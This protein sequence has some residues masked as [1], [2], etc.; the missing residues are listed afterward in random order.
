MPNASI[1]LKND[2]GK[3]K[4]K[5]I[6]QLVNKIKYCKPIDSF[7]ERE[8]MLFD[9]AFHLF[10]NKDTVYYKMCQDVFGINLLE[11]EGDSYTLVL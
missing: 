5:E 8:K 6:N 2:C 3:E 11:Y 7:S 1:Q 9:K 10:K 4:L